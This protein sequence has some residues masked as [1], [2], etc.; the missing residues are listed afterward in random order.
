MTLIVGVE[1]IPQE[2]PAECSFGTGD[3][4]VNDW[5]VRVENPDTGMRTLLIGKIFFDEMAKQVGYIEKT[6]GHKRAEALRAEVD[7]AVRYL[8]DVSDRLDG[9]ASISD[10]LETVK[11]TLNNLLESI[12]SVKGKSGKSE[13]SSESSSKS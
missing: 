5:F 12:E 11:R 7:N 4:S 13:G 9:I 1:E 8:H 6:E 3:A 10:D 2:Q